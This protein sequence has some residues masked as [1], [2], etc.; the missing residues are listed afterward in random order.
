MI[1]DLNVIENSADDEYDMNIYS[2][3]IKKKRY[4]YVC[5]E[6][7]SVNH[8]INI[9]GTYSVY[10]S[11]NS[12]SK[13]EKMDILYK[14]NSNFNFDKL[15]LMC[16]KCNKETIHYA[17]DENIVDIVKA[18]NDK[19]YATQYSCEGHYNDEGCILS[20][21]VIIGDVRDKFDLENPLISNWNCEY[22]IVLGER[23]ILRIDPNKISMGDFIEQ[24]HLDNMLYYIEDYM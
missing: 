18:L 12:L 23:T 7:D 13:K 11:C 6:C 5:S 4:T 15:R 1:N 17:L 16:P 21:F 8:K 9:G 20:Y 24:K 19:G 10:L 14:A 22:S 3:D 2:H